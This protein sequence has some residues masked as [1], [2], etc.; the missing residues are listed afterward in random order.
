MTSGAAPPKSAPYSFAFP[1]RRFTR[2][3]LNTLASPPRPGAGPWIQRLRFGRSLL[4]HG[5]MQRPSISGTSK[6]SAWSF[7]TNKALVRNCLDHAQKSHTTARAE[8]T[9]TPLIPSSRRRSWTRSG[10]LRGSLWRK[11][12]MKWMNLRK[13]RLFCLEVELGGRSI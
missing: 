9:S 1:C 10:Q 8:L 7:A 12:R 3:R 4:S 6:M 13:S 2:Q 5:H 11:R